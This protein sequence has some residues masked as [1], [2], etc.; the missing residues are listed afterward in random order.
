MSEQQAVQRFNKDVIPLEQVLY[1]N[2][3]PQTLTTSNSTNITLQIN[4]PTNRIPINLR[5]IAVGTPQIKVGGKILDGMIEPGTDGQ[6]AFLVFPEEIPAG[7]AVLSVDFD[8]KVRTDLTGMYVSRFKDATGKEHRILTTHMEPHYA[9]RMFPGF[10]QPDMKTRFTAHIKV[11]EGMQAISNMPEKDGS[12]AWV[13]FQ[14]TPPMSSYLFHVS[15]GEFDKPL[16]DRL[17]EVQLRVFTTPGKAQQGQFLLD[18]TKQAL[19]FMQ[20]YTGIDYPLPKLDSIALPEFG[21]GAMENWGVIT[22][23]ENYALVGPTTSIGALRKTAYV[24]PHEV[25]HQWFGNRDTMKWWNDLWLNESFATL[26]GF[27][28][29]D[30]AHSDWHLWNDFLRDDYAKA[31]DMDSLTTTHPIEVQ[32]NSPD[33]ADGA[34]DEISYGKG[35]SVLRM[36]EA[37]VGE[38]AFRLGVI[39]YLN[40]FAYSNAEAADLWDHI[41]KAAGDDKMQNIVETWVKQ[42]GLP[43]VEARVEG[44]KLLLKQ[45]RLAHGLQDDKTVWPIPLVIEVAGRKEPVRHLMTNSL[46]E[47]TLDVE[48]PE[49]VKVNSEQAGF[50][51]VKYDARE[52]VMLGRAVARKDLSA[53]DR[54]GFQNDLFHLSLAGELPL[55]QYLNLVAL[56]VVEDDQLVLQ[57]IY[58]NIKHIN[59][60]FT[61]NKGAKELTERMKVPFQQVL[62]RIGWNPQ[63]GE[64]QLDSILRVVCIDYLAMAEDREVLQIGKQLFEAAS[65]GKAKLH[66][67]LR[68]GVYR[69]AVKTRAATYGT[70]V[71]M[72]SSASG[73]AE[74][75]KNIIEALASF[76]AEANLRKSVDFFLS[77]EVN[78]SDWRY[79][80]PSLPSNPYAK[81]V[82]WQTVK[83]R[84]AKLAEQQSNPIVFIN[85]ML[86]HIIMSQIGTEQEKEMREFFTAKKAG[87]EMRQNIAFAAMRRNTDWL[88]NNSAALTNYFSVVS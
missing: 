16:E 58:K 87:Y 70:L 81:Q 28:A 8:S 22:Y 80:F 76:K 59:F 43:V 25:S 72:F 68:S 49:W 82:L 6:T 55:T 3:N 60:I 41:S 9:R 27:K 32:I 78:Q 36:I 67:D 31:M 85:F 73:D 1:I 45:K 26:V 50:F 86:D 61:E 47:I 64:S 17:G 10:D 34:F 57:D 4:K 13:T 39:N 19:D 69:I 46:E 24:V 66:A 33:D 30:N 62:Q 65:K 18:A 54:W 74:E 84:W 37:Y 53:I 23:R 77:G 44:S 12:D 42:P 7:E 83:D 40:E 11:P 71:N 2:A 15:I 88:A 38:K 56:Y 48:N 51:R 14:Q 5:E 20:N 75:R 29:A 21:A 63:Q 52:L 79:V 35:A